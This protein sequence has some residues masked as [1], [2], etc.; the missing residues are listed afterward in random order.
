M[1]QRTLAALLALTAVAALVAVLPRTPPGR[2]WLLG[3]LTAALQRSGISLDFTSSAGNPWTG[4]QLEGARL[5][6]PGVQLRARSVKVHYFLPSLISGELPLAINLDGVRGSLDA[7]RLTGG[8]TGGHG[9]PIRPRLQDLTV[10]D[11]SVTVQQVPYT[12]PSGAVSH[13]HIQQHGSSLDI[14]AQLSTVDGSADAT[15][16]LDLN[17]PTFDGQIIR[18]DVALA[19]HW[20]R[21][22]TAGTVSGPIHAGS[23]GVSADLV[24]QG[25]A[26]NA[27]GLRPHDV[28][29]TVELR[30]PLIRAD[31]EGQVLGGDVRAQGVINIAARQWTAHAHGGPTLIAIADWL[32]RH[33]LASGTTLPFDGAATA[34]ID[35]SGWRSVHLAGSAGGSGAFVGLPLAGLQADFRYDSDAGV[36]VQGT[37]RVAGGAAV[38]TVASVPHGTRIEATA[39]QLSPLPGQSV[40][41]SAQL[42]FAASGATGTVH[43][44]DHGTVLTRVVSL[45]LDAGLDSDGWQAAVRGRDQAG[46]V[47]DGAVALSRGRVSGELRARQLHLPGTAYPV[48]ASVR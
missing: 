20:F 43:A 48:S 22:V 33:S 10:S 40:D 47:L 30:Y 31:V 12:I 18:A 27:I 4:V 11:A 17:G 23:D 34:T 39:K 2:A 6:A 7:S 41:V 15:G 46:A 5:D 26:L 21:G 9:L 37:G 28:H 3:R 32:G 42:A 44:V 35:A 29:G 24:L 36:R 16:T 14:Q 38:V 1:R 25:G 13:V 8:L 19:R 45:T